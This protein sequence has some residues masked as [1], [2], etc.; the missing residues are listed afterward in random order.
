MRDDTNC[1]QTMT[2]IEEM[3]RGLPQ[4]E[5]PEG[6]AD[7][8]LSQLAALPEPWWRGQG[9]RRALSQALSISPFGA[10]LAAACLLAVFG[11][12][13]VAGQVP[14]PVAQST[15]RVADGAE[16]SYFMGRSLLAAMRPAEALPH[17]E[18]AIRMRPNDADYAFWSGVAHWALH[19]P[20][21]EER[22]Y[23]RAVALDPEHVQSRLYLGHN[24]LE[25]GDFEQALEQYNDVLA[26]EP[27]AVDALFNRG[28]ALRALDRSQAEAVAWK[29]LLEKDPDGS[30]ALQA[31]DY[32][33]SRGDYSFRVHYLGRRGLALPAFGFDDNGGLRPGGSE[34][35]RRIG[36]TASAMPNLT[37]HVVVYV[38][39]DAG[40]AKTRA[41]ALRN[42]LLAVFPDLNP[43]D[44]RPS[45][46]GVPD[47]GGEGNAAFS[48]NESVRFIG[49]LPDGK[50]EGG[51]RT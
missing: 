47:H 39:G 34:S 19:E 23:L 25:R 12:G 16:A 1:D 22:L 8:V 45:W 11:L 31:A 41:F 50:D 14:G 5:A 30:R 7:G 48:L 18:R 15:V 4:A 17:L 28:L 36:R 33:N 24:Y 20:E 29:R 32:L 37:L 44:V 3:L 21:Q 10:L 6:F 40:L 2:E 42:R 13:Y 26:Q 46:F 38:A 43:N 27:D 49:L 9:R 35:L 51:S